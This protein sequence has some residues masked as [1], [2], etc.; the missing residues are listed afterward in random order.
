MTKTREINFDVRIS[1]KTLK[2]EG[3]TSREI[4][5]K[6]KV[7]YSTVNYTLRRF[8]TTNCNKNKPR[9]GRPKANTARIDKKIVDLFEKF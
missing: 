9:S 2:D 1:I 4:E 7:P 5:E 6:L 8:K 3:Y